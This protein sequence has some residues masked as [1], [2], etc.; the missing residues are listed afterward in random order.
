MPQVLENALAQQY[1]LPRGVFITGFDRPQALTLVEGG[2]GTVVTRRR[3]SPARGAIVG[4]LKRASYA[5]AQ[6]A[7]DALLAFLHAQPLKVRLHG[8]SGRY[9]VAYTEGLSD[10]DTRIARLNQFRIPLLAPDPYWLGATGSDGP[11][12]VTGTS[13]FNITNPGSA[14]TPVVLTITATSTNRPKVENLTT[15]QEAELLLTVTT[16]NTWVLNGQTHSAA[17]NGNAANDAASNAY[18]IGGFDLAPGTNQ[19][20]ATRQAGSYSLKLD[21]TQRWY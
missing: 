16:G 4:S 19:I 11:R 1:V 21:W 3:P 10:A 6:A 13:N 5:D 14:P 7:L 9:L 8:A 18:L 20:R 17:R 15:G 12:S 2:L